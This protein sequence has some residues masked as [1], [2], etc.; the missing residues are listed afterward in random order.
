MVIKKAVRTLKAEWKK[1]E[2]EQKKKEEAEKKEAN[3]DL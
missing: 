3:N 1:Y 2:E